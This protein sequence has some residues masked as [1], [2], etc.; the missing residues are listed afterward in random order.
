MMRKKDKRLFYKFQV[1]RMR[2]NR[3]SMVED[4]LKVMLT[5]LIRDG[6]ENIGVPVLEPFVKDK[7]TSVIK[8]DGMIE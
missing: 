7:L 3:D 6:N 1:N 2:R 5:K 8:E 4:N